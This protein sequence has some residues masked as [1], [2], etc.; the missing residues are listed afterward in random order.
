MA[1]GAIG[2]LAGVYTLCCRVTDLR[3]CAGALS[4]ALALLQALPPS[5]SYSLLQ[6]SL[7]GEPSGAE[8]AL[9][10]PSPSCS[11]IALISGSSE[12]SFL[13]Q[14]QPGLMAVGVAYV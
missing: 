4:D 3:L 6:F 8:G 12:D 2:L 14:L 7:L 5:S 11:Q 9:V 13:L 1:D 10:G